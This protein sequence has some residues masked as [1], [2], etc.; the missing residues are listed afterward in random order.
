MSPGST[1]ISPEKIVRE[2]VESVFIQ[3]IAGGVRLLVVLQ[4]PLI[5]L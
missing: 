5:E 1:L 3:Q 4:R 2:L